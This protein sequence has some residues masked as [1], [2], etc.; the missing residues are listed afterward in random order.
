MIEDQTS[1]TLGPRLNLKGA[2]KKS[3][4]NESGEGSGGRGGRVVVVSS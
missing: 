3:R 2:G 1:R 4:T